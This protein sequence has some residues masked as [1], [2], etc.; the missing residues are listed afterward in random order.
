MPTSEKHFIHQR[1]TPNFTK[2]KR[3]INAHF[4]LLK[5]INTQTIRNTF[6]IDATNGKHQ[7]HIAH[8]IENGKDISYFINS[9]NTIFTL[10]NTY[11]KGGIFLS[12]QKIWEKKHI[13]LFIENGKHH[14]FNFIENG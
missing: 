12:L 2:R 5:I 11:V 6:L 14:T 4:T 3:N 13:S 8:F 7:N 9:I 10:W 1:S